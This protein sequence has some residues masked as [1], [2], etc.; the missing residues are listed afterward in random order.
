MDAVGS[1]GG[2]DPEAFGPYEVLNQIGHGGFA[3]VYLCT[4]DESQ[5]YA[6]KEFISDS[7]IEV[8][9][10]KAANERACLERF[11]HQN[12]LSLH[13]VVRGKAFLFFPC[14]PWPM[15]RTMR[16]QKRIALLVELAYCTVLCAGRRLERGRSA[17]SGVLRRW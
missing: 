12:V 15:L 7:G 9:R 11:D 16:F 14:R 4:D 2:V 10:E 8:D 1:A 3:T 13:D 17:G 6:V 5:L